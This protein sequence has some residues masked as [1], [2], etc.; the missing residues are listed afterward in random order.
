MVLKRKLKKKWHDGFWAGLACQLGAP[1]RESLVRPP[2]GRPN[3]GPRAGAGGAGRLVVADASESPQ[4]VS[5]KRTRRLGLAGWGE[6]N[7]PS[8]R[9][10]VG[11]DDM[12]STEPP[13]R[14]RA[15]TAAMLVDRIVEVDALASI[16]T[17]KS[18]CILAAGN[19]VQDSSHPL[20]GSSVFGDTGRRVMQRGWEP[21]TTSVMLA[22]EDAERVVLPAMRTQQISRAKMQ[23]ASAWQRSTPIHSRLKNEEERSSD[24]SSR[25]Q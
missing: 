7:S 24:R 13:S 22:R 14:M 6:G 18:R 4:S 20:D 9:V 2:G 15:I 8:R 19:E 16:T 25:V 23:R 17:E 1:P 10:R 3:L 12:L 21:V 5:Q 11:D